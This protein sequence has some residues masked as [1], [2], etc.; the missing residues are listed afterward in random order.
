M[1]SICC[2]GRSVWNYQSMLRKI[3]EERGSHLHHP[4]AWN[5]ARLYLF[6]I[7]MD[8]LSFCGKISREWNFQ[9]ECIHTHHTHRLQVSGLFNNNA[10]HVPIFRKSRFRILSRLPGSSLS[11]LMLSFSQF[12]Q[13]NLGT[14][15]RNILR[16]TLSHRVKTP[17]V[18]ISWN[19]TLYRM[20]RR[21]RTIIQ[22]G[23]YSA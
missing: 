20:C 6:G 13:E 16:P 7:E 2:S 19:F 14:L 8:R 18:T 17:Y 1:G 22:L 23:N 5:F 11:F 21:E 15:S 9:Y 4:E 10:P 12:L 3:T